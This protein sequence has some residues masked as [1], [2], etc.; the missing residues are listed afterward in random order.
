MT[1][2]AT[3]P[4]GPASIFAGMREMTLAAL[5]DVAIQR[6]KAGDLTALERLYRAYEGMVYTLAHRVCR[7][8]EDAE[9]VLQE[10]FFQVGSSA[11]KRHSMA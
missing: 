9:D 1:A 4:Y 2:V 7:S 11:Y 10:T 6:A 3:V 5:D 8:A